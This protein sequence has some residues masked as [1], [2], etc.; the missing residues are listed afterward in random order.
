MITPGNAPS[1]PTFQVPS[2][3]A[4]TPPSKNDHPPHRWLRQQIMDLVADDGGW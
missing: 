3:L 4:G 1:T 2:V